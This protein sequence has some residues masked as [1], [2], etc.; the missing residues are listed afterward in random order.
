TIGDAVMAAFAE[1]ANAA[2]AA[3]AIQSRVAEFN[4]A[5]AANAIT[6]KLGLHRGEC[7]A[8]TTAGTLDYF[9]AAVNL[10]A[11]LQ[12]SATIGHLLTLP[13]C[14]GAAEGV[15]SRR[16]RRVSAKGVGEITTIELAPAF[17]QR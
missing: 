16:A 2:R 1:P 12:A 17:P 11:R 6:I 5:H 7:I 9:G 15:A 13:D 10:A 8:V 4:A 3:L 14:V